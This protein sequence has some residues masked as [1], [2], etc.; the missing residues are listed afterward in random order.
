MIRLL[1]DAVNDDADNEFFIFLSESHIPLVN[2]VDP[3]ISLLANSRSRIF[4]SNLNFFPT[5]KHDQ[6]VV[7]NRRHANVLLANREMW[8]GQTR[9]SHSYPSG[10]RVEASDNEFYLLHTLINNATS[11]EM[12]WPEL[13]YGQQLPPPQDTQQLL[14]FGRTMIH[15]FVCWK[16][17]CNDIGQHVPDRRPLFYTNVMEEKFDQEVTHQG[18]WF[19]RKFVP[20]CIVTTRVGDTKTVE[21]W[22]MERLS[23]KH[24]VVD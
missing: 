24:V 12:L 13:N 15:T 1:E 5:P 20:G 22:L 9:P 7:L 3:Y 10:R 21:E 6:W 14:T 11:A 16:G 18:Y 8:N 4:I 19:A 23:L 2:F 17:K